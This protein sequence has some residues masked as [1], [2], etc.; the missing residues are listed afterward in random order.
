MFLHY[1]E[2]GCCISFKMFT[3][4]VLIHVLHL[5]ENHLLLVP[6]WNETAWKIKL[7]F[8]DLF[9]KFY[10]L[11]GNEWACS[12]VTQIAQESQDEGNVAFDLFIRVVDN[13]KYTEWHHP[14]LYHIKV[15]SVLIHLYS[16]TQSG[17]KG[18]RKPT[19][20]SSTD[21]WAAVKQEPKLSLVMFCLT[22]SIFFYKIWHFLH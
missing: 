7:Y 18:S 22:V 10:F 17:P 1:L 2:H 3:N 14:I 11:R 21:K 13:K 6:S 12:C 16:L 9:L 20:N 19:L 5:S 4:Y 15:C 8:Y